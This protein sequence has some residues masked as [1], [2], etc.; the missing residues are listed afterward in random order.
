MGH[1]IEDNTVAETRK[2]NDH[3]VGLYAIFDGHSERL[4]YTLD[5]SSIEQWMK[6]FYTPYFKCFQSG[7]NATSKQNSSQI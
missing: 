1:G 3:E 5:T 6:I 7:H 4:C 2:I